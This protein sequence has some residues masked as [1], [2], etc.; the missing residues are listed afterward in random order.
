MVQ[1]EG[2]RTVRRIYAALAW[3]TWACIVVQVFLAGLGTFADSADWKLHTTFV[4]YFE[5]LPIVM[6]ILSFFGRIRGGLRWIGL[7]LFALISFQH[8]SVQAFSNIGALAAMH[9]VVA[10]ALFLGS[11]YAARKSSRWLAPGIGPDAAH[12]QTGSSIR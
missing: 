4:T 3:L 2:N 9:T 7:V 12:T 5:Y 11:W 10:L 6:F 1:T 8:M